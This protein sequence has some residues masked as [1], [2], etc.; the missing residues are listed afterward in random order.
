MRTP[1]IAG[2]WKMNKTHL[3]AIHFIEQLG[4]ELGNHDP[5]KVEVVLCPPHTALR[6]VQTTIDD[7]H[8]SFGLGAQN[9]HH[10]TEGAFTGEVSPLMLKALHVRY[11]I[12]GHSERRELFG[13]TDESVNAKVKAAFANDLVPIMCCG[14]TDMERMNDRTEKKVEG[15][16]REGLAGL[17]E[18]Q[19]RRVVVAYEPIWAIGTGKTAT[20][21][22]AQTTI[23]FIRGVLNDLFSESVG[24]EIRILYGGSMKAGNAEALVRQ[25]DIDGGLVGGAS[26]DASEFAAMIKAVAA[27]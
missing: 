7:R 8:Q 6:S 16:V 17:S 18:E 5:D 19:A 11:V 24:S 1:L 25:P 9:M 2:N 15:Q 4:H 22:D 27:L 10:E 3:D 26:L 14:E 20:P 13:E 12:L 23:S 21:D